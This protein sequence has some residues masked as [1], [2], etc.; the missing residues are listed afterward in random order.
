MPIEKGKAADL[1]LLSANPAEKIANTRRIRC[2]IKGG[3]IVFDSADA[4][5]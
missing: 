5:R 2:V 4:E 3:R 1:V